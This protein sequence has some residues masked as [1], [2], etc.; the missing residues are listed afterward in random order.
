MAEFKELLPDSPQTV[1]G[2]GN[3]YTGDTRRFLVPAQTPGAALARSG[4]IMDDGGVFPTPGDSHPTIAALFASNMVVQGHT[5][6]G[7]DLAWLVAVQYTVD[8]SSFNFPPPDKG[9]PDYT[10]VGYRTF[11]AE[12]TIPVI[13]RTTT[14]VIIPPP[15]TGAGTYESYRYKRTDIT[16]TVVSARYIRELNLTTFNGLFNEIITDQTDKLHQWV[17]RTWR[18]LGGTV[19]QTY[20]A[21]VWSVRYEWETEPGTP[22][23]HWVSDP[24]SA[25]DF[26]D[27]GGSWQQPDIVEIPP[28][29]P[30]QKWRVQQA[31]LV[32]PPD[33]QNPGALS[34]PE[35]ITT[36]SYPTEADGWKLLPGIDAGGVAP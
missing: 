17:G 11:Q 14:Y 16:T 22:Y 10:S 34:V 30:F 20:R 2:N 13:A 24:P 5:G 28:R 21:N 12:I 36:T 26:Y 9:D 32:G 27:A 31:L 6:A 29:A 7:A 3:L 1:K 35:I 19:N 4:Q 33:P 8:G 15:L 25:N 23:T 18:F